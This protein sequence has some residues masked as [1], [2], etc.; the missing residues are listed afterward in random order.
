MT[1]KI[2]GPLAGLALVKEAQEALNAA[3]AAAREAARRRNAVFREARDAG[4]RVESIREAA[5]VSRTA[6]RA[7]LNRVE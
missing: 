5:G 2:E 3:E 4:W 1:D 6:V 7:A